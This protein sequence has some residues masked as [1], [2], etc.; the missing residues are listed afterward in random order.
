M[1]AQ[2]L[3]Y[4][5]NCKVCAVQKVKKTQFKKQIFEPGVQPMEFVSMDLIGD[6]I[7]PSCIKR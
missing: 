3:R 1:R 2:I 5:K 4:C 7:P 6:S